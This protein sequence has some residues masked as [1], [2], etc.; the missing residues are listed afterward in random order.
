MI[1]K[2]TS[3]QPR[4]R[5]GVEAFN[6][7]VHPM[8]HRS[9]LI[10]SALSLIAGCAINLPVIGP[11]GRPLNQ[12]V[13]TA[14]A[15]RSPV[16]N[17]FTANPT[18]QASP[19]GAVTFASDVTDPDGDALQFTWSSTGGTLS[20]TSGRSTVWTPPSKAGAYAVQLVVSDGKGGLVTGLQN[21]IV[22][23]DFTSQVQG[24]ASVTTVTPSP[25]PSGGTNEASAPAAVPKLKFT[26]IPVPTGGV[27]DW[28]ALDFD[29]VY[30]VM[31]NKIALTSDAGRNWITKSVG[32]NPL[33]SVYFKDPLH[34]WAGGANGVLFLTE[35][36]GE[37]WK[38]IDTGH[39]QCIWDL[40]FSDLSNGF[41]LASGTPVEPETNA[42]TIYKTT[43]GGRTWDSTPVRTVEY[44]TNYGSLLSY[45]KSGSSSLL[46]A[47][48]SQLA[49][50][51]VDQNAK[52]WCNL[53]LSGKRSLSYFHDGAFE[54]VLDLDDVQEVVAQNRTYFL[55][56]SDNGLAGA[57]YTEDYQTLSK[58]GPDFVSPSQIH[59]NLGITHLVDVGGTLRV[60]SQSSTGEV[61]Y[62]DS[63]DNGK[64]WTDS[65]TVDGN[66]PSQIVSFD[67]TRGWGFK[68]G[69]L[70]RSGL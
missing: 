35:D 13:S 23:D 5:H 41:M 28:Q 51:F 57:V 30:G 39:S 24:N 9:V 6:P 64:S 8:F 38:L 33:Y 21:M 20:S 1:L 10:F 37:S 67:L 25:D 17:V 44:N 70:L 68:K 42:L 34:G 55:K 59:R 66:M 50:L 54:T 49:R 43:D 11:D 56:F 48:H 45:V 32:T 31:G 2:T 22:N 15:N 36:G 27:I 65:R 16:L 19:G 58:I 46:E 29:H 61:L 26:Q 3:L 53:M 40:A 18:N 52:V 63:G 62:L 47:G 12:T 7:G 60:F 4:F 14:A 69:A